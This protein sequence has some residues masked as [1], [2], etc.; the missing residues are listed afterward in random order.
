MGRDIMPELFSRDTEASLREY[1][2]LMLRAVG[3]RV[4]KPTA[5]A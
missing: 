2:R 3:V 1:V 5:S 4:G